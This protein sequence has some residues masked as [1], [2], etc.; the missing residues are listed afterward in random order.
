MTVSHVSLQEKAQHVAQQLFED[1]TE[2]AAALTNR[3]LAICRRVRGKDFLL[4]HNPGGWRSNTMEHCM[5]WERNIVN[6]ISVN[7][8]EHNYD[9]GY[10]YVRRQVTAFL[11]TNFGTDNMNNAN[12]KKA[13]SEMGGVL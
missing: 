5:Q 10:P 8:R 7:I 12:N 1:K 6:G 3:L 2:K 11:E 4:I 9:W 13:G